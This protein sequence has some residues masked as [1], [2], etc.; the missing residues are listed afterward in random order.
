MHALRI[1]HA[2][3]CCVPHRYP[4]LLHECPQ[5]QSASEQQDAP[6]REASELLD[7]QWA[8]LSEEDKAHWKAEAKVR[9][10]AGFVW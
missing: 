8:A 5:L 2:C 9:S 10:R 4:Q 3:T 6:S 7:A 1:V